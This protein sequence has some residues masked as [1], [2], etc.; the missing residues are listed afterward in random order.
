MYHTNDYNEYRRTYTYFMYSL[1]TYCIYTTYTFNHILFSHAYILYCTYLEISQGQVHKGYGLH[2]E[3]DNF[4]Q[5]A[6]DIA[7]A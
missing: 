7:L 6:S 5:L 3:V 1:S 2:E 4:S